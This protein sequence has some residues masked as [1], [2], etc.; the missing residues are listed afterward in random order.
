MW[1]VTETTS[2]DTFE[3]MSCQLEFE[4]P[5]RFLRKF[6]RVKHKQS[7]FQLGQGRAFLYQ[8]ASKS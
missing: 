6:T 5:I 8:S 4:K 3:P 1:L 7:L 2:R